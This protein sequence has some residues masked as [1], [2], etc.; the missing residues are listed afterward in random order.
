MKIAFHLYQI[1]VRGTSNAVYNYAHFNEVLFRN[2]S[3][4]VVPDE[5]FPVN[6]KIALTC[7]QNR[8]PVY[9]YTSI[10]DM[11]LIIADCDLF[12]AI[13]YGTKDNVVSSVVK[14]VIHCVFDL[15]EPHGDIYAG[16]SKT[17]ANKFNSSLYVPHMVALPP[18]KT[19][20]NLRKQ[21]DIPETALVF[22]RHGGRDTFDL[23]LA[24]TA[25]QRVVADRENIYFIFVNTPC[26]YSHER[27]IHLDKIISDE[28]KNKFICTCDAMI[29][30]QSLG[31]TFGLSIAEFSVNNKPIITYGGKVWNDAHIH[32]LKEN[33]FY[34]HTEG[35]LYDTLINFKADHNK[36]WNCYKDYNPISVMS[37]FKIRFID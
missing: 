30:A 12:Y 25:I 16:V 34:Y 7:F 9:F 29:H 4:I 22:G 15:S 31:E 19:K 23:E 24:K 28:D 26:F 32:I 14:T 6:D 2:N 36:D 5:S 18:S 17:L 1:D 35:E 37:L 10:N 21:F 33:A 3:I 20:K 13:K 27:I 11:E 8:F